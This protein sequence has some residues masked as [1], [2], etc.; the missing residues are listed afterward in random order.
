MQL[1]HSSAMLLPDGT[2]LVG[3]GGS[4]GPESNLNVKLYYPPYLFTA[5]GGLAARSV[6]DKAPAVLNIGQ[7][8]NLQVSGSKPVTRVV[9]VRHGS[10]THRFNMGQHFVEL[11]FTTAAP[12]NQLSAQVTPDATEM[13]P[14]FYMLFALDANGV[15][16][17]AKMVR[18][19]AVEGG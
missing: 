14:G 19:N 7:S 12:G 9:M 13:P 6:I 5:Q 2:V 8:F 18:I 4:P 3:G 11:S 10:N 15:P 16:S 17:Y 1:Y